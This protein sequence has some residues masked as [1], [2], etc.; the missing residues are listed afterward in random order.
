MS[1]SLRNGAGGGKKERN[2]KKKETM[3]CQRRLF[4]KKKQIVVLLGAGA[5]MPWIEIVNKKIGKKKDETIGEKIKKRFIEDLSYKHSNS[6]TMGKFIFDILEHFYKTDCA[7]FET[8]LAVLEEV[9]NYV[10]SSTNGGGVNTSNTSFTPAIFE[11]KKRITELLSNK[12]EK[13]QRR[14]CYEMFR[15]YVNIV[16]D[17]INKYNNKVLEQENEELNKNLVRFTKYFLSKNYSVKYYTTNY[18]NLIP[19]VTAGHCNIYEGLY[20]F[21]DSIKRFKC[22][23]GLFRKA[24]LSHFNLHGSIFYRKLDPFAPYNETGYDNSGSQELSEYNARI[25]DG[26][27][28]SER[29]VFSPIITGY[30][31]TQRAVNQ[32][33]SLGFNAFINDCNDCHALCVVGYSVSD[34]HINVILSSYIKWDNTRFIYVTKE[35]D[36][37]KIELTRLENEITP[38]MDK[39][40]DKTWV[41]DGRK[42]VY[43]KGFEEF[44]KD[45]SNW[46][47]LHLK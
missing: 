15:T 41:H 44:L 13:E 16:I 6:V 22:D 33:F 8:F 21:K 32:P 40:S 45:R 24:R 31:K 1:C 18:D 14:C 4:N 9:L 30:N 47:Y 10:F 35:G 11:L 7:N 20:D 34:P 28:P 25:E 42:H 46:E 12:D 3:Y 37:F 27:N 17:E 23:L 36:Y 19:Q 39:N 2:I 29:L 38:I 26:G 43:K 5:A